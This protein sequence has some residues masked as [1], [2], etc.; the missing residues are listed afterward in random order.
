MQK[1]FVTLSKLKGS[2][3]ARVEFLSDR[4]K[5]QVA[6][7]KLAADR[8]FSGMTE[9]EIIESLGANWGELGK[10][11]PK[12]LGWASVAAGIDPDDPKARGEALQGIFMAHRD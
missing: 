3:C 5:A 1:V 11:Y 4:T 10:D 8:D 2:P 12:A 9:T 7:K 6:G